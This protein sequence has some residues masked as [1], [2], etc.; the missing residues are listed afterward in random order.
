MHQPL[1]RLAVVLHET[2][3]VAIAVAVDPVKGRLDV[4]PERS[5]KFQV[6]GSLVVGAGQQHEQRRGIHAAV[7]AA[8]WHLAQLGHFSAA[9]LVQDLARLGVLFGNHLHCLGRGQVSQHTAGKARP[10]PQALQ[11]R[12]DSVA[13][14]RRVEPRH[15]RVGVQAGGQ[16]GGHH[17]QVGDGPVDPGIDLSVGRLHVAAPGAVPLRGGLSFEFR[18]FEAGA[19]SGPPLRVR[20]PR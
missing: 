14:K 5:N 8:K 16:L 15:A 3:A 2:V 10:Q 11:R 9:R 7:V 13:A 18:L 4:G 20:T 6:A 17:V 1:R 12:D 19:H